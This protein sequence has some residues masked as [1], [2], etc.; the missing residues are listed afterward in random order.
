MTTTKAE[1]TGGGDESTLVSGT[2]A[3]QE[4]YNTM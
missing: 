3:I 2:Y 1:E 4:A